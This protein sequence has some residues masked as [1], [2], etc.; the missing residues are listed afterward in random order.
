M[1]VKNIFE[2]G[3]CWILKDNEAIHSLNAEQLIK[4]ARFSP[5]A[6]KLVFFH[7]SDLKYDDH[8]RCYEISENAMSKK[9]EVSRGCDIL[10]FLDNDYFIGLT[11]CKLLSLICTNSGAVLTRFDL[12]DTP[13]SMFYNCENQTL[14]VNYVNKKFEEFRVYWP[15]E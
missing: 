5:D 9:W 2:N 14:I 4:S 7:L 15:N 12:L 3:E 1:L 10:L 11:D 6:S 8:G 13:T